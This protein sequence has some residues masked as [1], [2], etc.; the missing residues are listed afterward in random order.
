MARKSKVVAVEVVET[1][2]VVEV[3]ELTTEAPVE[4]TTTSETEQTVVATN[5]EVQAPAPKAKNEGV[6]QF[7]RNL[8][9]E[10]LGNKEILA[11]VHEQYGNT[12]TT[13]ACVAWYRN[14][15]KK[16]STVQAKSSALDFIKKFAE[17]SGANAEEVNLVVEELR[18]FG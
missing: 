17:V 11:I 10:G 16:A 18:R 6:G 2:Q 5:D 7:I 1:E 15:V 9:A 14:K 8:I 13:Y 12:S 3:V 4:S